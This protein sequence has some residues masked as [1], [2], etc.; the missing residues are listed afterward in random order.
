MDTNQ[1]LLTYEVGKLSDDEFWDRMIAVDEVAEETQLVGGY[2][3]N[4]K[5]GSKTI[6]IPF[7][8][9]SKTFPEKAS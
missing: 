9:F 6:N 5:A 2:A 8:R 3:V 1:P 4:V 7:V